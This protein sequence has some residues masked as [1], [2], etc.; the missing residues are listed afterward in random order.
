MALRLRLDNVV[1]DDQGND[2]AYVQIYNDA[3]PEGQDVVET[4][5]ASAN[6]KNKFKDVVKIKFLRVVNEQL[7]KDSTK[8][9][10]SGVLADL[11][12]E[13]H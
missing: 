1:K 5:S 7:A 13:V 10:L 11:E 6:D 8:K 4:L 12:R 9:V 3:L 2:F